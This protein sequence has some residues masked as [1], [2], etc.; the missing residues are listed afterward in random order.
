MLMVLLDKQT[1]EPL[2]RFIDGPILSQI[3]FGKILS[4]GVLALL[5]E[6][7]VNQV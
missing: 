2:F 1:R 3:G 4:L 5:I 6:V 7:T